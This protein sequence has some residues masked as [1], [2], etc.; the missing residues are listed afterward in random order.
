M[1]KGIDMESIKKEMVPNELKE[2][3]LKNENYE[4]NKLKYIVQGKQIITVV[5]K[6]AVKKIFNLDNISN[7][8]FYKIKG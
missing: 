4:I 8:K 1:V 5:H 3:A 7:D 2:K 6:K